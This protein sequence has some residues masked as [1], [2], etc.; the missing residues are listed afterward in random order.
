MI[1]LYSIVREK[2]HPVIGGFIILFL[3]TIPE[4]YAYTYMILFDYSNSVFFIAGFY[5]LAKYLREKQMNDFWFASYLF[6]V[7]TYIRTETLILVF[8]V[9]PLVVFYMY[10]DKQPMRKLAIN[11]AILPLF[12]VFFYFLCMNIFVKRYIPTTFDVSSQVNQ[13]LSDLSPFFNRLS[14]IAGGLIFSE[15]G[16]MLYGYFINFFLLVLLVDIIFFRKFSREAVVALYGV[17][18]VYVGLAVIGYLLPLA[19][20]QNTTKRGL[21][22][23]F[24]LMLYYMANSTS[25]MRLSSLI[26]N[27]EYASDEK[28]APAPVVKQPAKGNKK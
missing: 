15:R 6:G 13:H 18:V 1:W 8:M 12:T 19:D 10:R 17:A 24:P 26:N 27:W 28:P 11:V 21:F 23:M 14:D 9:L 5:F 7:A 4:M 16:T 2:V 3:L 20:L 25:L 22:K